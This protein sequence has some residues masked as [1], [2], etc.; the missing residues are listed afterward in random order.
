MLN[1]TGLHTVDHYICVHR[2]T[3]LR[4][5]SEPP[6][7]ELYMEASQ[8][9]GTGRKTYWFEQEMDLE[10]VRRA[11]LRQRKTASWIFSSPRPGDGS[12]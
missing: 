12:L 2:A 5:V 9:H 7:Y 1:A 6:I 8:I 11:L 3:V 10:E 4:Y